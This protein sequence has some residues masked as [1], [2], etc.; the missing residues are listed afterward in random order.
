MALHRFFACEP[1]AH[2]GPVINQ[3]L[4]YGLIDPRTR[5]IRYIGKSC[6]GMRRPKK[7][8]LL[9]SNS[10]GPHCENWIRA[11][12]TSGFDYEIVVL[13]EAANKSTL[14]EL[15][16]FWIAYGRACGWPLT[17]ATDGGDGRSPGYRA[18]AETRAKMSAARKGFKHSATARKKLSVFRRSFYAEHPEEIEKL[19]TRVFTPEWRAKISQKTKGRIKSSAEIQKIREG[20]RRASKL[21]SD[22]VREIRAAAAAGERLAVIGAR[23]GIHRHNVAHI[24]DRHTWKDVV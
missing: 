12:Q 16:R 10:I 21:T 18:S 6:S 8:R 3:L 20:R 19:R 7:H 4:I 15:E 5:M 17:N 13:D 11:L 14:S 2:G 22:A 9:A 24:R 1:E 23:F